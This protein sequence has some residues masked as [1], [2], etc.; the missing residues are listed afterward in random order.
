MA[1]GELIEER[2]ADLLGKAEIQEVRIRSVLTCET[3]NGVCAK[4]YGR[5]LA[6]G[7]PVN[8]GEAVGVIAAQ[9]IGE[10]GTQLTMRTFHIGGTANLVDSS[11]IESNF[12]GT[13]KLRNRAIAKDSKGQ[14]VAMSRIMSV[15]IVDPSGKELATH[16]ISYGSRIFVDEGDTVKRGTKI[17]QWDPYTRPILSEA[18]RLRRLRRLIEGSSVR[19]QTDE[20]KGTS[21]RVIIDWRTS[22]KGS[23]LKP[24]ILIKDSKGKPI[25]VAR[26]GDARYLLSVEAVPV[27]RSRCRS[28]GGRRSRAYSLGFGEG[29]VTSLV[30]CRA[31]RNSSKL[32]VQGSRDPRGDLGNRRIRQGLQEQAAHHD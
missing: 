24:A 6:R 29:R 1:N 7:K 8:I 5:D 23:E 4:C 26:G 28:E 27:G 32:A 13:V 17:A 11:F 30:V 15:I 21:N 31:S 25:K 14:N 2:H 22:P 3:V 20:M 12:N 16:K 9:S 18:G 19:E 10:P